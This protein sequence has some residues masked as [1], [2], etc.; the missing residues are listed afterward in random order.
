MEADDYEDFLTDFLAAV[1]V[2]RPD[3]LTLTL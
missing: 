1:L 3:G 2:W